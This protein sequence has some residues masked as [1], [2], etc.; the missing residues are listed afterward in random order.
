MRN[1]PHLSAF[2]L[3]VPSRAVDPAH[4]PP[5]ANQHSSEPLPLTAPLVTLPV[6][7]FLHSLVIPSLQYITLREEFV[8]LLPAPP[9][10]KALQG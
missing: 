7:L 4:I 5:K 8:P 6:T 2:V 9:P 10:P 3:A 1:T